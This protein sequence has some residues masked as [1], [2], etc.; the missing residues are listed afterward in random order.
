MSVIE[1][2]YSRYKE[3]YLPIVPVRINDGKLWHEV[4]VFVDSGA[5]YSVL[6]Y[7]EAERLG[8]DTTRGEKL[9]VKVGD[10]GYIS[11]NIVSL[12]IRIGDIEF[13]A[14]IGFSKDLGVGFNILG[15]KDVFEK[16]TICFSDKD[17][18]IKFISNEHENRCK[19]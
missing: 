6:D 17:F 14:R 19:E 10:G 7:K 4:R 5:T 12:P 13:T 8:I 15:R 1:F 9:Y 2:K 16:F 18:V 11:V 3:H